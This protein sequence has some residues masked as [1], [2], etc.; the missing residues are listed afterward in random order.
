MK[1]QYIENYKT[2]MREIKQDTNEWKDIQCSLIGRN[3]LLKCPEYPKQSTDL[4]NSYQ[5]SNGIF[6][7]N[8]TNNSK[9]CMKP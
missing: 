4:C 8:R 2:L 6:H 1:D 9:I 7:R 3:I 5:N